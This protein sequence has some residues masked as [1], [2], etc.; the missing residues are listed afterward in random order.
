M[1]KISA[2]N[3]IIAVI[4][5]IAIEKRSILDGYKANEPDLARPDF[6]WHYLLQS[7]STMGRASGWHGLIGNPAN[8]RRVT[9]EALA[10]LTPGAREAQV[11]EVCRAA[12]VRMP[13][14]KADFIIGCFEH[15]R[16]LGGPEAAKA[17]LLAQPG[18]DSKIRFL[19]RFPGIGP[20]YSRNMMMD[21][22]HEEFR[23]SIAVDIRIRAISEALGL[24]FAS[25]PEHESF[26]LDVARQAGL[27]GWE[28]DRLL[29]NFRRQVEAQLGV[30]E[31]VQATSES[32]LRTCKQLAM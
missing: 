5:P 17:R 11:R 24:S 30:S 7:F 19:M 15:V 28:L 3:R 1:D 31:P 25:Y 4:R 8:Y 13:D 21:V 23:D 20:K 32:G 6:V 16:Q 22:Y 9:Y 27:N 18:R 12:K 29:F 14:R 2:M 10:A 26:Y